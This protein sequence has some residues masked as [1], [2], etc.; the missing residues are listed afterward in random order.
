MA[1]R[2]EIFLLKNIF[3]KILE[4][5]E[6]IDKKINAYTVVNSSGAS[7]KA[8]SIDK[9]IRNGAEEAAIKDI[10]PL[11]GVAVGIKDNICTNDLN[12][13]CIKD[14]PDYIISP[15]VCNS[16]LGS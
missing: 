8:R 14:V 10:G 5:I 9:K 11:A 1:S 15:Y 7:E 12:N 2:T 6:K 4:R 16:V 13:L 3:F